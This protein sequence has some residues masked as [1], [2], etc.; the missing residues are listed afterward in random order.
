MKLTLSDREGFAAFLLRARGLGI[1]NAGLFSAMESVPRRA[2]VPPLHAGEAYG[3]RSVPIECGE[4]L[5]GLDLQA[6]MLAALGVDS[7]HR[8]L[9]IGTGSGYT[10]AVL[11]RLAGR[12]LSLERYRRLAEAARQRLDQLALKNVIIRHGDATALDAADGTYDRVISWVA[13]ET[14]PRNFVDIVSSQGI[15]ITPVGATE[16]VQR[17]AKLQKIGSRF[18]REDIGE[19]RFTTIVGGLP[20]IL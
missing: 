5:E 14:L 12:V 20:A 19:G 15:M 7:R 3:G 9:E 6:R 17:I 13:F 11:S 2:F 10:A 18:D 4:T 8:V 1:A 16:T